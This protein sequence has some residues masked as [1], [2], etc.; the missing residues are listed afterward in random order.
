MNDADS[1]KIIK[2]ESKSE[3]EITRELFLEYAQ[4][5]DFHLCFQDFEREVTELP[6]EYAPAS[7]SLLLL[8]SEG[9]AAGCV[10]LRKIDR[11]VCE[12]KRLYVRPEFR[13]M[14]FGKKLTLT[15]IDEAKK[16]GYRFIRLDTVPSM[17]EAIKLYQFLGFKEIKPYR[18]NPIEG[19][20]FME[21]EL[22]HVPK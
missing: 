13:G 16:M 7:G 10:A 18:K 17:K 3:V 6:G 9:K 5:L 14:G 20:I 15:V 8:M 4:S 22:K 1:F 2:V 11:K 21:L 19:A 12:M